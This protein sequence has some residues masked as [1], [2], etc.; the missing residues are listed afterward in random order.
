MNDSKY[1]VWGVIDDNVLLALITCKGRLS[2]SILKSHKS[3]TSKYS[4]LT[5]YTSSHPYFTIEPLGQF[6]NL[7]DAK[8]E[9]TKLRLQ[10]H[11]KHEGRTE[12]IPPKDMSGLI[13][14]NKAAILMKNP[15]KLAL[16]I[17]ES[18]YD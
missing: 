15:E 4:N 11:P 14:K 17:K 6:D 16:F 7:I 2:R 1:Y 12:L 8:I 10:L 5:A 9:E 3:N 18:E 13:A